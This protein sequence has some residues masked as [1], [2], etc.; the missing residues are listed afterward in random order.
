VF[1]KI[2]R[3]EGEVKRRRGKIRA[4]NWVCRVPFVVPVL[5]TETCEQ[6]TV[7]ALALRRS[8]QG[9][10]KGLGKLGRRAP[11]PSTAAHT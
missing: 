10:L 2:E 3:E 8:M 1:I 7:C 5:A 11:G 4:G 6:A 9:M